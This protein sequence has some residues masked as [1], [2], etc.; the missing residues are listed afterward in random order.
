LLHHPKHVEVVKKRA[1]EV[2]VKF[3]SHPRDDAKPATGDPTLM[4]VD[5][6]L[7]NLGV[8]PKGGS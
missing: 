4:A 6:L 5:F 3:E 1:E 2:G 8:T 7:K